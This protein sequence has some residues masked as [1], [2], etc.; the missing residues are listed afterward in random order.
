MH[1][2][3]LFFSSEA[4]LSVVCHWCSSN[5]NHDKHPIREIKVYAVHLYFLLHMC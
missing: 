5:K 3:W 2:M 4:F 1:L